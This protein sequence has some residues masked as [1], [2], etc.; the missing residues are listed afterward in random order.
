MATQHL[1]VAFALASLGPAHQPAR[2]AD[3][4]ERAEVPHR[5]GIRQGLTNHPAQQTGSSG[6]RSG[7]PFVV[8]EGR[9]ADDRSAEHARH[10]AAEQAQH[11]RAF[12]G[13]IGETVAQQA[14]YQADRQRRDEEKHQANFFVG[15]PLL[16]V[17][18]LAKGLGPRQQRGERAGQ[19]H[20]QEQRQQQLFA[21][22]D[23]HVRARRKAPRI[24]R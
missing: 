14:Q 11:E 9:Q 12:D 19:A 5:L 3:E 8:E 17:Q 2:H 18:H 22:E 20:F 23:F 13:E 16:G 6:Q 7:K 24:N 21:G 15:V 4:G 10:A 1:P